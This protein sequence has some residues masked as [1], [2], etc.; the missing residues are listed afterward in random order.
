[1]VTSPST[2]IDWPVLPNP[3]GVVGAAGGW[4]LDPWPFLPPRV[5]VPYSTESND[6]LTTST[7]V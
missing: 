3:T 1:M 7:S 6:V 2:S 5:L 4:G